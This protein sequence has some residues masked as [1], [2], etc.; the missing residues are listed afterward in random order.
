MKS[1]LSNLSYLG[2]FSLISNINNPKLVERSDWTIY[3]TKL[4]ADFSVV[5]SK[6]LG[7]T[8]QN[9]VRTNNGTILRFNHIILIAFCDWTLPLQNFERGGFSETTWKWTNSHMHCIAKNPLSQ[10]IILELP[11]VI[12]IFILTN[13]YYLH[14]VQIICTTII[15]MYI[16]FCI[17]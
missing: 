5:G 14:F 7:S 17:R 2:Y 4:T 6:Y 10:L 11:H 9:T 8:E 12:I 16:F 15:C 3:F 1:Y 13:T